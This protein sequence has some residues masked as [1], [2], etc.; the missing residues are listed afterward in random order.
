MSVPGARPFTL[1]AMHAAM[2]KFRWFGTARPIARGD[3]V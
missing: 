3:L 2:L 1:D